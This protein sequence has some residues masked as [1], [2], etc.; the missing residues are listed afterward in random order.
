MP[1]LELDTAALSNEGDSMRFW[2]AAAIALGS[3]LLKLRPRWLGRER[4]AAGAPPSGSLLL[5]LLDTDVGS[6]ITIG[7]IL[8]LLILFL[9][10]VLASEFMSITGPW[11]LLTGSVW[12]GAIPPGPFCWNTIFI[13]GI[14]GREGSVERSGGVEC[15]AAAA[16]SAIWASS[17]TRLR[18]SASESIII[19]EMFYLIWVICNLFFLNNFE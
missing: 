6:D 10:A 15:A 16:A 7:S 4:L 9:I 19:N 18:L 12:E 13:L 3:K 14:L 17:R 2:W 1:W 5:L 11:C 8:F